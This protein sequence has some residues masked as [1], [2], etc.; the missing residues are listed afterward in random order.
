VRDQASDK[1]D[2]FFEDMGAKSVKNIARPVRVHR[3]QITGMSRAPAAVSEKASGAARFPLWKYSRIVSHAAWRT[4]RAVVMLVVV[5]IVL[6]RWV[7]P[8]I[9]TTMLLRFPEAGKMEQRTTALAAISPEVPRALIAAEDHHFCLHKGVDWEANPEVGSGGTAYLG[10][11]DSITMQLAGSL[12]LWPGHGFV[13]KGLEI[14]L[15]YAIDT[16]WPKRRILEVYLN[17]AEW[18][19]GIYGVE[20]AAEVF[21]HKNAA[22]LTRNEAAQ[23]VAVLQNPRHLSPAH[24]PQALSDRRP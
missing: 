15:A 7:M 17:V 24:R 11:V 16:I 14:G 4:L 9:T 22:R 2:F 8:P 21:Y 1:L 10:T 3:V 23:L 18:G 5:L 19:T 12:F 13:H 20:A 6:Y